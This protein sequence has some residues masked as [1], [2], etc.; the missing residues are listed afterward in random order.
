MT[1][2]VELSF[3]YRS[4]LE[5]REA[6]SMLAVPEPMGERPPSEEQGKRVE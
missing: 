5:T 4:V 3:E 1:I 6:T 2:K